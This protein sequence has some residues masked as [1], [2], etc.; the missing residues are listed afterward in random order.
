MAAAGLELSST[1]CPGLG[2][3]PAGVWCAALQQSPAGILA[4]TARN[5][6]EAVRGDAAKSDAPPQ[7]RYSLSSPAVSL[8]E[9][10]GE[11]EERWQQRSCWEPPLSLLGVSL[12][13]T[14]A[15]HILLRCLGKA[16]NSY[17]SWLCM[18]NSKP[19][20]TLSFWETLSKKRLKTGRRMKTLRSH[21]PKQHP[22]QDILAKTMVPVKK[23][24][25]AAAL[26]LCSTG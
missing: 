7:R 10:E 21:T 19:S 12:I 8:A 20:S 11:K 1:G 24:N 26:S 3:A 5:V 22:P 2:S 23:G 18:G 9:G 15:S 6:P 13:T 25:E 16:F 4:D 17:L 14:A